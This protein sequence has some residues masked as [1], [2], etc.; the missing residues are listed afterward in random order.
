MIEPQVD[1]VE[2]TAE[3]AIKTVNATPL[4]KSRVREDHE[5]I[6]ICWSFCRDHLQLSP[7]LL[8]LDQSLVVT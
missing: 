8:L 5:R 3:V 4:R 2:A 7:F 1:E 6:Q